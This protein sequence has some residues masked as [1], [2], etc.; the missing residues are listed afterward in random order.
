M[1]PCVVDVASNFARV[2]EQVA[3]A[4]DRA[5]RSPEEVTIIGAAKTVHAQRIAAAV[6]AG[7]R[8]VGENFVQEAREKARDLAG[9]PI[10]WHFIGS[11][12]RNKAK[13]ALGLF[14]LI[15]SLD[16]LP[17]AVELSRQARALGLLASC[18]VEVNLGGEST[19]SGID[20]DELPRLVE[21]VAEMQ[22]I[23]ML[24]LMAI[25]PFS[26]DPERTRPFFVRLRELAQKHRNVG[27]PNVSMEVLSMGMSADFEVAVEEG[28][29]AVRIGTAIF[30]PRPGR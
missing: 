22:D 1:N 21:S 11:L 25:P 13:A 28:A 6:E 24:G 10:T 23:R 4:A 3:H 20:P 29:T 2:V 30:G 5:G 19:K 27:L 14:N 26:E 15:H 17:M 16:R 9:L 8:H 7:L 18:L 12:Q